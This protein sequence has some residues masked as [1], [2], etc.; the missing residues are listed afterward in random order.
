MVPIFHGSH[1]TGCKLNNNFRYTQDLGCIFFKFFM[2][3]AMRPPICRVRS[4]WLYANHNCRGIFSR[5]AAKVAKEKHEYFVQRLS[6]TY[7][8]L[9][10]KKLF[11]HAEPQSLLSRGDGTCET[12]RSLRGLRPYEERAESRA[13]VL[14]A[15]ER[16]ESRASVEAASKRLNFS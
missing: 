8:R 16:A 6:T 2:T 5:Q 9:A 3:H 4:L 12:L 7:A 10:Q 13:S 11:S 15:S 14:P 1:V